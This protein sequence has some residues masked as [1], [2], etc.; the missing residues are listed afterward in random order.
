MAFKNVLQTGLRWDGVCLRGSYFLS[1]K[2]FAKTLCFSYR[3]P[4]SKHFAGEISK[5]QQELKKWHK[6]Y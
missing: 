2:F 4:R 1:K 5:I 3:G 6:F